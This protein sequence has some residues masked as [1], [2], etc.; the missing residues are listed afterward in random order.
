MTARNFIR[1]KTLDGEEDGLLISWIALQQQ[2]LIR[3]L[4]FVITLKHCQDAVKVSQ[5]GFIL[6]I[7]E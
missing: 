4:E 5:L 6:D 1:A 2:A 3:N 7:V